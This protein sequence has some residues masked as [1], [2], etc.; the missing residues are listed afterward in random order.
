M[1]LPDCLPIADV[2]THEWQSERAALLHAE[3][4][5][6]CTHAMLL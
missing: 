6:T 2:C 4:Y 5:A 1:H 3:T